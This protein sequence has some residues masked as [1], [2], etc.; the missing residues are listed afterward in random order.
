LGVTSISPI[1]SPAQGSFYFLKNHYSGEMN[2][3]PVLKTGRLLV[4]IAPHAGREIASHLL[5]DLALLGA[6]TVLDSGNRVQPYRIAHL[7][8]LKTVEID[9]AAAH[10]SI[11]RAFTCYQTL[12]LLESAEARP[13]PYL[14]LDLLNSFYDD[15]IR[16]HEARHL[17]TLCLLEIER[18]NQQAPLAILLAPPLLE[19]RA[20][21]LD[22]VCEQA[23]EIYMPVLS[24]S[25]AKQE[26]LF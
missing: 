14:V 15:Q 10:L 2:L 1:N 18:L 25:P 8:R 16:D 12:A 7:L 24:V 4:A 19:E 17:L 3:Y 23:D 21:L 22:M 5:A 26:R 11:Q 6:V 20:F 9:K 13:N